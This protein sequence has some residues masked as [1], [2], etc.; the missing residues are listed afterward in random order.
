MLAFAYLTAVLSIHS[1]PLNFAS[2]GLWVVI[3]TT[4]LISMVKAGN[5][6]PWIMIGFTTGAT[7]IALISL[8]KLLMGKSEFVWGNTETLAAVCVTIA[9]LVWKLTTN[10][11]GVISITLAMYVAMIPTLADGWKQPL[12]QDP[13]F[14]GVCAIGCLLNYIGGEKT[15][16]GRFMPAFGTFFNGLMAV[17]ALRQF[18]M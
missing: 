4:L 18:L 1:V 7:T 9:L 16:A 15:I 17:F 8:I 14:W 10:N 5:K 2:W 11:G 12:G 6:R 3:D 13:L